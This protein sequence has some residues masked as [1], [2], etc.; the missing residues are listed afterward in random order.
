MK[1]TRIPENLPIFQ[2]GGT[3]LWIARFAEMTELERLSAAARNYRKLAGRMP[4]SR[5]RKALL[6]LANE[7]EVKSLAFQ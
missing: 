3:F 5:S 1:S 6:E 2:R 7:C 4:P